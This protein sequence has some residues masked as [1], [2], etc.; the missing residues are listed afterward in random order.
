VLGSVLFD[1]ADPSIF[2]VPTAPT[3]RAPGHAVVDLAIFPPRRWAVM[4]D[5]YFLP[6]YHRNCMSEFAGAVVRDQ[7]GC[8]RLGKAGEFMPLGAMLNY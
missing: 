3:H 7:S 5:T 1:H 8:G 6:Y 2:T 4:E